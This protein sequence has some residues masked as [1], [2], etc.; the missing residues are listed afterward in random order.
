[1]DAPAKKLQL[2]ITLPSVKKAWLAKYYPRMIN[3]LETVAPRVL[4]EYTMIQAVKNDELSAFYS[5]IEQK[6]M[7]QPA[8]PVRECISDLLRLENEKLLFFKSAGKSPLQLYLEDM[9][10]NEKVLTDLNL[11]DEWLF[12]QVLTVSPKIRTINTKWNWT[13]IDEVEYLGTREILKKH[14]A[15]LNTSPGDFCSMFIPN[16]RFENI[17]IGFQTIYRMILHYFSK[18]KKLGVA[19]AEFRNY[20]HS[21]PDA[22]LKELLN[23]VAAA[24]LSK[25]EDLLQIFNNGIISRVRVLIHRGVLEISR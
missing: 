10:L 25:R 14:I 12:D 7:E 9:I 18:P 17:E 15:N 22:R 11:S 3:L 24:K 19:I 13:M 20:L 2:S 8:G 5:F 16:C 6:I 23:E 1:M 21:L 4:A